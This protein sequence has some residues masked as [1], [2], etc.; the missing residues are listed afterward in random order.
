MDKFRLRFWFWHQEII[1]DD[2]TADELVTSAFFQNEFNEKHPYFCR[3]VLV[4]DLYNPGGREYKI[5]VTFDEKLESIL[6]GWIKDGSDEVIDTTRGTNGCDM[7]GDDK[8]IL[9]RV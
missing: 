8:W 4:R 7:I 1:I 9:E 6:I 5:E 3:D 2:I